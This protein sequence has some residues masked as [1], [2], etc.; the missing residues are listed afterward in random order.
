[1][2]DELLQKLADASS[3]EEVRSCLDD[4]GYEL[5]ETK[6]AGPYSEDEEPGAEAKEG[7]DN[8][9]DRMASIRKAMKKH[10][11][12]PKEEEEDA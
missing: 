4:A 8:P 7:G 1:M 3:P 10:G 6:K 2:T 12:A 5:K 11:G 9:F